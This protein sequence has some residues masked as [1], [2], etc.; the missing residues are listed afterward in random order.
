MSA[1]PALDLSY[2]Q[3]APAA[4]SRPASTP[5]VPSA[6]R[7]PDVRF[8]PN[9]D[10][11]PSTS[12]VLLVARI[13]AGVLVLVA[14][15]CLARLALTSATVATAIENQGI[16]SQIDTARTQGSALEIDQSKLSTPTRI[17]DEAKAMGMAAPASTMMI[18]L[19][20]DVVVTDQQGNLSLSGSVAAVAQN[21]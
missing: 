9:P 13:V 1:A 14:A 15:L 7:R 5:S 19:S 6:P 2:F 21:A 17:K 4:P 3:P 20:G 16:E 12:P 18:D 10:A 8:N 11:A